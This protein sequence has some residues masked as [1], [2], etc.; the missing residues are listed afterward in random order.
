MARIEVSR[1]MP[2]D[3]DVVWEALAD[4]AS[5]VRWMKDAESLEFTTDQRRGVGTSMRV[6]T[7]VG[8]LRTMDII[9][10]RGWEEGESIGVEHI[11]LVTGTGTLAATRLD[12]STRVTWVEDLEFP[13]WLGGP[14]TALLAK[15]VL[16][17]IWRGNLERLEES[18]SYR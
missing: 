14:V 9:A 3:H 6:S 16:A 18:L 17:A 15:P 5:H 10:V 12:G 11:G 8:P 2:V 1:E 13:W 7:R 4:L